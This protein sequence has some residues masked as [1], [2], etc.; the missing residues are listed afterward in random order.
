MMPGLIPRE[1]AVSQGFKGQVTAGTAGVKQLNVEFKHL[2]VFKM[3]LSAS[4]HTS[5]LPK[6]DPMIFGAF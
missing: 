6:A 5:R 2:V 1:P 3:D 4:N